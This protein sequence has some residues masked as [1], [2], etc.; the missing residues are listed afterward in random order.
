MNEKVALPPFPL[1]G[2]CQCKSVKYIV[3]GPPLVFYLCHCSECQKQSSSAFGQSMRVYKKDLS[4]SGN[5][6]SFTRPGAWGNDLLCEF[7]PKCGTR[8]F[9][10]RANYADTLNIKA[11]TLDDTSWLRPAGHI[12]TKSKQNWFEIPPQD[13]SYREQP[14]SFDVLIA[15]WRQ[16]LGAA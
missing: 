14:E 5:L 10:R 6:A 9:H 3:A 7:C 13:L 16:M 8:L 4:I 2:G 12:W 15:R 11:G 1:T